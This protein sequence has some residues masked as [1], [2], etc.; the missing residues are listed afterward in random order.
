MAIAAASPAMKITRCAGDLWMMSRCR[1]L[2]AEYCAR[3][4]LGDRVR[5]HVSSCKEN[6]TPQVRFPSEQS[7]KRG[8]LA[9]ARDLPAEFAI[10]EAGRAND[11]QPAP[12]HEVG[13]L[14][15]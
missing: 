11:D 6:A 2:S 4:G 15:V 12:A 13:L 7:A 5:W 8:Q 10:G 14:L 1:A 9:R 3:N